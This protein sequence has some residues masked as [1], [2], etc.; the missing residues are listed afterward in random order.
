MMATALVDESAAAPVTRVAINGGR[1]LR[2]TFQVPGAKN[3]VLPMMASCLLTDET[4]VIENIPLITDVFLMAE[5]LRGLGAQV[6]LDSSRHSVAITASSVS[7]TSPDPRLVSTMRAS[8]QVT[9]P[10]LARH[11]RFDCQAPG[12]CQLGTRPVEVDI[13]GFQVMGA[14][15]AFG[16][17]V[18]H[19]EADPLMGRRVYLDYPS[20]TGTQNLLMA[21]TLA[22]GYTQ[23]VHASREP[24]V[25]ALVQF[26]RSMGAEINGEG[27]S[28]IGVQGQSRLFGTAARALPDRIVG[29]TMAVAAALS[30]G[31][32]ELLNVRPDHLEPVLV[33]LNAMGVNLQETNRSVR[34]IGSPVLSATAIQCIPFPGFPTDVQA[35]M[36]TLMTQASGVSSIIERVY[37]GNLGYTEQLQRMGADVTVDGSTARIRGPTELEACELQLWPDIRAGAALLLAGLVARGTTILD[38]VEVIQRGYQDL[39]GDLQALGADI[40]IEQRPRSAATGASDD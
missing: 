13:E 9:G 3:A 17:G 23:I 32:V 34:V 31:D 16:R 14:T 15:V 8:F 18:Y 7:S 40:T 26:L 33:K 11:G 12:G 37:D 4:C 10:L 35:P 25:V 27:T 39:P 29:S 38:D 30:V 22:S 24:E 20:H 19:A 6:E 36:G 5:L 1:S 2:G 21:A 28:E